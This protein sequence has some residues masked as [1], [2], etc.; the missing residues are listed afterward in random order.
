MGGDYHYES[1][2]VSLVGYVSMC[3][4]HESIEYSGVFDDGGRDFIRDV[5]AFSN[6]KHGDLVCLTGDQLT[7]DFLPNYLPLYE[8]SDIQFIIFSWVRP[9]SFPLELSIST[10]EFGDRLLANEHILHIYCIDYDGTKW[11]DN[12]SYD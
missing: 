10:K 6:I 8:N 11:P 3:D 4:V 5:A 7:N 2:W 9:R 1:K 12:P